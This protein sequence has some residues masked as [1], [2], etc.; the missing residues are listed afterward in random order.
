M[1]IRYKK[2]RLYTNLILGIIWT[3]F[4]VF[5][6][7][8]DDKRRWSEYGY[9]VFGIIYIGIYIYD[10]TNQYLTIENGMIKKNFIFG[11]RLNLNEVIAIKKFAGDYTL[12]TENQKLKINT[13]FIDKKS[14]AE[15]NEIL[16][17]L[18]LQ[19]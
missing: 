9:L 3:V 19:S 5:V 7:L 8:E 2:K 14:L 11:K 1:K 18:K 12:I 4:G 13:V 10:I 16:G 17:R 15:L 6:L